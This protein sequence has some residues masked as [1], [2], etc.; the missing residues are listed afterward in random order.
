MANTGKAVNTTMQVVGNVAKG[1]EIAS[2]AAT[3]PIL[4]GL[5][6][7]GKWIGGMASKAKREEADKLNK[8]A[9]QLQATIKALGEKQT[10]AQQVELEKVLAIQ[11]QNEETKKQNIIRI[12]AISSLTLLL[13]IGVVIIIKKKS[14]QQQSNS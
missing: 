3:S 11:K 13:G 8:Q 9:Q 6:E 2:N 12:V 10:Q 4:V 1:A 14:Q 7:M 5:T